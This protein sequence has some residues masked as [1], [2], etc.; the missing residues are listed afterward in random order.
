[1]LHSI[2]RGAPAHPIKKTDYLIDMN[3]PS[4]SQPPAAGEAAHIVT[5]MA[6]TFDPATE[7]DS[8]FI[9]IWRNDDQPDASL[10]GRFVDTPKNRERAAFIV[11]ACN[12]HAG[13]VSAL[14]AT[15]SL[16]EE[17]RKHLP[18]DALVGFSD[19]LVFNRAELAKA[20]GT[21]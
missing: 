11:R 4:H 6:C 9:S 13:L 21:Q 10:V 2:E 3:S 7:T 15:Q 12:S 17:A 5:P 14:E 1:L 20:K 8:A 16:L 18:L 19:Q